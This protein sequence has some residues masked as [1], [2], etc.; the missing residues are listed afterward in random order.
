MAL[1]RILLCVCIWVAACSIVR[2]QDID[3]HWTPRRAEPV[4][5]VAPVKPNPA[6]VM[7]GV[8][9]GLATRADARSTLT[10]LSP[11][12]TLGY[13]VHS[14]WAI[15]VDWGIAIAIDSPI[16]QDAQQRVGSGNPLLS[17]VH[18]LFEH[19]TQRLDLWVGATVPLAWLADGVER[20][21]SRTNYAYALATRGLWS[22]WLW[23][24]EQV[25]VASGGRWR[26][27][28]TPEFSVT[29]EGALGATLALS[30]VTQDP[31]DLYLQLAPSAELGSD[32]LRVG[33][34]LQAV[35]MT[36]DTDALQTALAPYLRFDVGEWS[37]DARVLINLD[38][39]LGFVG[40][41][42]D[43]WGILL[44]VRGAL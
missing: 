32:A 16:M 27:D 23:A 8:E 34:R 28:V 20:G 13:R 25:G 29:A 18:N 42:L 4:L 22:P 39:P 41:G 36:S 24:P 35:F 15:G 5:T 30:D 2:A 11:V 17:S 43:A 26:F 14:R 1:R 37:F 33:L 21:F 9:F 19:D 31:A 3:P 6:R 10:S 40:A 44:A 38:E 7:L 12:F